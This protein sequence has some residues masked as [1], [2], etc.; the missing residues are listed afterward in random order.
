M[1]IYSNCKICK[2]AVEPLIER[3][4][5]VWCKNCG[6]IF[7][8]ES[9]DEDE[10]KRIYEELYNADDNAYSVHVNQGKQ[11]ES[12][13][14]PKISRG[15]NDILQ[16]TLA[17]KPAKIAEIG[18][19]VGI[20]GKYFTDRGYNYTGF[21]IDK[22]TAEGARKNGINIENA[23]FEKL[24]EHKDEFDVL[25]AFEVIEHI[26]NLK[27]CLDLIYGSL[28]QNGRFGFTVPNFNKRNNYKGGDPEKLYQPNPPTHVNFF[29]T[30]NINSVLPLSGF[31]IQ[32]LKPQR[33]PQLYLTKFSTYINIVKGLF[34]KFEGSTIMCIACKE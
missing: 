16:K 22:H 7:F 2:S 31:K 8:Q 34:G 29:T 5:I 30:Q 3:K 4:K 27:L 12:G 23:P 20:V 24:A 33:F 9:L 17:P 13:I 14:Q 26:D 15:R 6:L 19:G 18:A 1:L 21:E 25:L 11:I 28:K 32:F 10:V